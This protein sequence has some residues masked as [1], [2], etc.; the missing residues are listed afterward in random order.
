MTL[1]R[2]PHGRCAQKECLHVPLS[3]SS[4]PAGEPTRERKRRRAY[5]LLYMP[6]NLE[7]VGSGWA[8]LARACASQRLPSVPSSITPAVPI[9]VSEERL[10]SRAPHLP[11]VGEHATDGADPSREHCRIRDEEEGILKVAEEH[12]WR[13]PI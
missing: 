11:I 7:S 1:T 5:L 4:R 10:I 12:R 6:P 8:F 3:W 13:R 9:R 2:A